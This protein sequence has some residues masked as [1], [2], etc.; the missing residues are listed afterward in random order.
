MDSRKIIFYVMYIKMTSFH[1]AIA[2]GAR[3]DEAAEDALTDFLH[4]LPQ[5]MDDIESQKDSPV[6][7]Y[8]FHCCNELPVAEG[9]LRLH[10]ECADECGKA[11]V[12]AI[13]ADLDAVVVELVERKMK[14]DEAECVHHVNQLRLL[15]QLLKNQTHPAAEPIKQ[16]AMQVIN[17]NL[18]SEV[19]GTTLD[20]RASQ[21]V[22]QKQQL[23][24]Q[25][26]QL[27]EQAQDLPSEVEAETGGPSTVAELENAGIVPRQAQR[28]AQQGIKRQ[29]LFPLDEESVSV[30]SVESESDGSLNSDNGSPDTVQ[31]TKQ[32][33]KKLNQQDGAD[34]SVAESL[35]K[36]MQNGVSQQTAQLA[37]DLIK[38]GQATGD[39]QM[40]KKGAQQLQKAV[41]ADAKIQI[42]QQA[43]AQAPTQVARQQAVQQLKVAQQ[44]A[45]EVNVKTQEVVQK[46][47]Q[48]AD[49]EAAQGVAQ[50]AQQ[51]AQKALDS[52]SVG[53]LRAQGLTRS[54]Q[55]MANL[56]SQSQP[57]SRTLSQV[58]AQGQK[59]QQN[60]LQGQFNR[61]GQQ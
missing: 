58:P 24:Q 3:G 37:T 35:T 53:Q 26:A 30:S 5:L 13:K 51:K 45:Q 2:F 46:A 25:I 20:K 41:N 61:N 34:A 54:Q 8:K 9:I 52:Q 22:Q 4:E 29:A 14:R 15:W 7:A 11:E 17:E 40:R 39:Q 33:A 48:K 32:A 44:K 12:N 56:V 18:A 27:Q 43:L 1:Y 19:D 38:T 23:R 50:V 16:Q 6:P 28:Q 21:F 31:I 36:L 59:R 49:E 47:I 55:A 10:V 57:V 42:A 60:T